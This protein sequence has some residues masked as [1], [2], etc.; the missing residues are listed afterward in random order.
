MMVSHIQV[1]I[2]YA[3]SFLSVPYKW[4][5]ESPLEG[6]DCSG[7]VQEC[8]RAIGEDPRN[9]QTAQALYFKFKAKEKTEVK[10]G[11]L[12]FFGNRRSAITHVAIALNST[13]MIECG[14]G[15][16]STVSVSRAREQR[17]YVRIR[18]IANRFDL[19]AICAIYNK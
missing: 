17:A 16:S 11:D 15:N 18:P 12:L 3:M 19:I 1:M 13:L 4:G 2:D 5:G 6:F 9:D 10:K 7:F 14:G 8:L